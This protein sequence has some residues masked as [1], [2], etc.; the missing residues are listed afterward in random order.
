MAAA[1]AAA[2]TPQEPTQDT[3][4]S[5]SALP[6]AAP[7]PAVSVAPQPAVP[8]PAPPPAAEDADGAEAASVASAPSKLASVLWMPDNSARTC[9]NCRK[10][11]SVLVRRHHCRSCGRIFCSACL[12]EVCRGHTACK[13]GRAR[14]SQSLTDSWNSPRLGALALAE[15]PLATPGLLD[16]GEGVLRVHRRD[17]GGAARPAAATGHRADRQEERVTW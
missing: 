12:K 15:N 7:T 13:P 2:G 9:H 5:T 4:G 3:T 6:T 11:F 10:T 16:A 17:D 14:V 8:T 1:A